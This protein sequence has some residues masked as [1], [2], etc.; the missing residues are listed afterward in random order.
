MKHFGFLN[1]NN[2]QAVVQGTGRQQRGCSLRGK[3]HRHP[4]LCQPQ[5]P[6]TLQ[7]DGESKYLHGT[8]L[9]PNQGWPDICVFGSR[10]FA[11]APGV[12]T[13]GFW[14]HLTP[15]S[16]SGSSTKHS[17]AAASGTSARDAR[18]MSV[19]WHLSVVFDFIFLPKAQALEPKEETSVQVRT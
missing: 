12:K 5:S 14:L 17:R 9:K 18:D 15:H 16:H 1:K 10:C 7:Q 13:R 8:D 6:S 3:H 2:L 4:L 11:P 19:I